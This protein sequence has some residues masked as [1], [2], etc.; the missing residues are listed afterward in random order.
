M[1]TIILSYRAIV[2]AV[3]YSL[4]SHRGSPGSNPGLVMWKFVVDKMA[5][6]QKELILNHCPGTQQSRCLPS[7]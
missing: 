6:G 1:H 4:A 7:T 3:G 5:Q 2:Q